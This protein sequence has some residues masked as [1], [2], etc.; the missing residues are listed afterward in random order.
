MIK[1]LI[2]KLISFYQFI[3][4]PLLSTYLGINCKFYPSC[5]EYTKIAIKRF[6]LI[7]GLYLGIKRFLKCH[8][9]SRG[10]FDPV[11]ENLS[12]KGG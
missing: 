8:P 11:P 4:S 2:L 3:I 5:S 12:K 9:F 6:G 1:K 10:G 7:K